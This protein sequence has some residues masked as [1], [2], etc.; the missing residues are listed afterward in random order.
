MKINEIK[1]VR[2]EKKSV[3]KIIDKFSP[4]ELKEIGLEKESLSS[5]IQN[6]FKRANERYLRNSGSDNEKDN[7][8]TLLR[9]CK[10]RK[11]GIIK[12]AVEST[13]KSGRYVIQTCMSDQ[14]FIIDTIKL[15]IEQERLKN[16]GSVHFTLPVKRNEKDI[17]SNISLKEDDVHKLESITRFVVSG[18]ENT[19]QA[20]VV[21]KKLE[22]HLKMAVSAVSDFAKIAEALGKKAVTFSN[23][24]NIEF[25]IASESL[26]WLMQDNFILLSCNEIGL[27]NTLLSL[28]EKKCLGVDWKLFADQTTLLHLIDDFISQYKKSGKIFKLIKSQYLSPVKNSGLL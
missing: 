6:Y 21:R 2:S 18:I 5:F 20:E 27:S 16:E 19:N 12:V 24:D 23:S 14:R 9:F 3:S 4:A 22:S 17:I 10:T 7:I 25:K 8:L 11:R 26:N 1:P 13:D 28:N 15:C